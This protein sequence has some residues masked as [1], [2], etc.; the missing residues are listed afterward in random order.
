[1]LNPDEETAIAEQ[2]G[3]ARA[4]VRR[5][6]L[7]SHLLA[8]LSAHAADQVVFFGGTALS[9]TFAPAGRLSE[10]IDLI[11]VQGRRTAAELVA[12]CLVRGTRREY[13]GLVGAAADRRP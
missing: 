6:H 8:A 1:M 13:P 2:F 5:D 4:Q 10:D 9:R 11:A 3:V 12:D 7:I